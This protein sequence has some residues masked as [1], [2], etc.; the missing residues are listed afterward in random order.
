MRLLARIPSPLRDAFLVCLVFFTCYTWLGRGS[1]HGGDDQFY[2]ALADGWLRHG[3]PVMPDGNVTKWSFGHALVCLPVGETFREYKAAEI[4]GDPSGMWQAL[5]RI[6]LWSAL[7]AAVFPAL[8]YLLARIG[9]FRRKVAFASCICIGLG[10]MFVSYSQRLW[11]DN[12]LVIGLTLVLIGMVA[13]RRTPHWRG[14]L[15][16]ALA[17][18]FLTVVK[19]YA[20]IL[21]GPLMVAALLIWWQRR[22]PF[23]WLAALLPSLLG[24]GLALFYN[25]WRYQGWFAFG[26]AE[27]EHAGGAFSTPLLTGLAG[28][29]LSAGKGFFW[30]NPMML[31]SLPGMW[32]LWRR[33]RRICAATGVM[34]AVLVLFFSCWEQ[35]HGDW[36]WGPRYMLAL[37]PLL[38][39]PL[40]AT[41]KAIFAKNC[42][43]L[44]LVL[45]G[46]LGL[47]LYVQALSVL[48]QPDDF[49]QLVH[50]HTP[51]PVPPP[52]TE[53]ID[54]LAMSHFIPPLSPL[55]GHAW[56]LRIKRDPDAR[57]HPP[58]RQYPLWIGPGMKDIQVEWNVWWLAQ[59]RR[60]SGIGWGAAA[61]FGLLA[62][63]MRTRDD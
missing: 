51:Q 59:G 15:L 39:L 18:G 40:A 63:L 10:S 43:G 61:L 21:S 52:G 57:E 2:L 47:S 20:V 26:Y 11:A 46:L 25:Y 37:L 19:P 45:A 7:V 28:L 6:N 13:Y 53:V 60:A 8:L 56:M 27:T 42:W 23:L 38:L 3:S 34:V 44:R 16:A 49:I 58:W 62:L 41:L 33:D 24:V 5:Y 32:L 17:A 48:V 50:R 29:M 36:A 22:D 4:A 31:L 35:W 9:G 55:V 1:F 30:Y 14:L 54:P 12:T